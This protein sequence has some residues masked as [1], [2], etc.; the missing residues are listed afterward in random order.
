MADLVIVFLPVDKMNVV[1]I[2]SCYCLVFLEASDRSVAP[3]HR[4][5]LLLAT[6]SFC[7]SYQDVLCPKA[8]VPFCGAGVFQCFGCCFFGVSVLCV[9]FCLWRQVLDVQRVSPTRNLDTIQGVTIAKNLDA[10]FDAQRASRSQICGYG[11]GCIKGL[12]I[13]KL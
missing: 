7:G 3:I 12:T 2:W 10:T 11:F 6:L 1:C 8:S 13:A 9:W 5:R 4:I